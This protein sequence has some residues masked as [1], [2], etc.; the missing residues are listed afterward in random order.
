MDTL[1]KTNSSKVAAALLKNGADPNTRNQRGRT[2][3]HKT[4]SLDFYKILLEFGADPNAMDNDGKTPLHYTSGASRWFNYCDSL[5]EHEKTA[6]LLKHG[7]DPNAMDTAGKTPFDYACE[8]RF[9]DFEHAIL[10]LNFGAKLP[11]QLSVCRPSMCDRPC[12]EM[13]K[14]IE[15]KAARIIQ[16]GCGNWL[17]KPVCKDGQL[18]IHAKFLMRHVKN[19]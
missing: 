13:K 15:D 12:P 19:I 5:P 18:G 4:K 17:D 9:Y 1:H 7:A 3:L 14:Y 16:K 10:L 8:T 11:R 6:L 2:A